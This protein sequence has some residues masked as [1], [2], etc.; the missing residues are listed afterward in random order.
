[1]VKAY[2]DTRVDLRPY[3]S[4]T[5]V[6]ISTPSATQESNAQR[7]TRFSVS[8]FTNHEE[9]AAK[10]DDEFYRR[11]LATQGS[12]YFRKRRVYPRSF[13]WRVVNDNKVLEVQCADLTKSGVDHNEYN[14]TLRL[15][16]QE[17]ILPAGVGF[18]DLEDHDILNVFVITASKQLHTLTL[19]PEWLRRKVAIDENVSDWWK[20]CTP[21]P[22]SFSHPHR[23]HASSP[24]ELFISLDNG[25]LLRLTRRSGDDGT[26]PVS[27]FVF[28]SIANDIFF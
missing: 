2:K 7:R 26:Y 28:E 10:D 12:I 16:F 15:N 9:P 13:L 27:V 19:R 8:S 17:E 18:A 5:V 24:L 4:S 1:M 3:S 20:S 21:A 14:V 23:L 11:Y 22:L 6:N 25:S